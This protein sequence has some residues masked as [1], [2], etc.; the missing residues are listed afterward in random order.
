M[1]EA[2]LMLTQDLTP[3]GAQVEVGRLSFSKGYCKVK[4]LL[5]VGNW[6]FRASFNVKILN[7]LKIEND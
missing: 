2:A 6:I 4:F 7:I 1:K 3:E 5:W